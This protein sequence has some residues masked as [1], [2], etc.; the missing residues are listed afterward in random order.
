MHTVKTTIVTDASGAITGYGLAIEAETSG[1]AAEIAAAIDISLALLREAL[2]RQ[3]APQPV[4]AA[5]LPTAPRPAAPPATAAEAQARFFARYG[6][7]I[8]GQDW[9]AVQSYLGSRAPQPTTVEG[10]ISAAEAVRDASRA[11]TTPPAEPAT[12]RS[13]RRA[14]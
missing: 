13:A 6:A 2:A 11:S 8:G 7:A 9:A 4:P 10:W 3:I 14:A 12:R 5:E 1:D